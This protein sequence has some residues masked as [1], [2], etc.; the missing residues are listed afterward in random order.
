VPFWHWL[1][2][3]NPEAVGERLVAQRED[4]PWRLSA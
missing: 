2:D 1:F 3:Q 4:A